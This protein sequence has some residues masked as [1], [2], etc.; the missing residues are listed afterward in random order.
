MALNFWT[1][2]LCVRVNPGRH[3][4]GS[5]QSQERWSSQP[6]PT[7]LSYPHICFLVVLCTL[8]ALQRI[9]AQRSLYLQLTSTVAV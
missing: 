2:C 9:Q 8:L 7:A 6:D 3:Q 5:G 4:R 1:Q